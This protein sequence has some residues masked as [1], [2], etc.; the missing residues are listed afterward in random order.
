MSVIVDLSHRRF[1]INNFL[2]ARRRIL[3]PA[4]RA[5]S[6]PTTTAPFPPSGRSASLSGLLDP[7]GRRAS[8]P[9]GPDALQ[10]YHPMSLQTVPNG[11]HHSSE[12]AGGSTRHMVS[13]MPPRSHHLGGI[14]EYSQSRQ[15]SFYSP[16]QGGGHGSSHSSSQ[17]MSSDVPLSAPPSMSSHPYSSSHPS[18]GGQNMYP[19]LLPSPRASGHQPYYSNDHPSHSN[20]TTSGSGYGTPQ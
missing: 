8:M 13:S 4:H 17:Y 15:T 10:L 2:Q 16:S 9:S 14:S 12:Y 7:I 3:A 11:H 6:G 18:S 19:S 20:S 1:F 5:A